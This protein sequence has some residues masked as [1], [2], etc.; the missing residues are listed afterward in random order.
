MGPLQEQQAL[1][2]TE[3][4]LHHHQSIFSLMRADH[5]ETKTVL[6]EDVADICFIW[7]EGTQCSCLCQFIGKIIF[8]T[9]FIRYF[10]HLHFKC[11]PKSPLYPPPALLPYLLTP[12]SWPW[13]FPVQGHVKFAR[14]RSL[15]SQWWPT[16]PS[17][18]IYAA[19]DTSSGGT[20]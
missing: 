13:S 3:P 9:F 18:A 20:D 7:R 10:L 12:T 14:P 19:R 6:G 1:L 5:G 11:Y 2:T 17:S 8:P 4:S 15:S 16:R